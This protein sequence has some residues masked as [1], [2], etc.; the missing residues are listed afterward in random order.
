MQY[1]KSIISSA[2]VAL[3]L[4]IVLSLVSSGGR[5]YFS[6][7]DWNLVDT[8]NY[9]EAQQY[10]GERSQK[11]SRWESINNAVFY[12]AFWLSALADW[13]LYFMVGLVSCVLSQK[14]SQS[15]K[16]FNPTN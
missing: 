1:S 5:M 3:A 10:L 7:V 4:V 8:M 6:E 9:K 12:S 11:V 13:V 2:I 15:N 16:R 14:L